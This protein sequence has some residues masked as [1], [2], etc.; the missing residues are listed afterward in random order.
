[1]T[2]SS[3]ALMLWRMLMLSTRVRSARAARSLSSKTVREER[4]SKQARKKATRDEAVE[5]D[6]SGAGGV[7]AGIRERRRRG[8]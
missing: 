1:M 7:A 4:A 3:P 2:G 8:D 5:V 6:K